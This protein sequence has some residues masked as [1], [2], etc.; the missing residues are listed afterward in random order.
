M[1][2]AWSGHRKYP[3][4][5]PIA[6]G[7]AHAD[8]RRARVGLIETTVKD[9][10]TTTSI[11]TTTLNR[12]ASL[13]RGATLGAV[14]ML[15]AVAAQAAA[16]FVVNTQDQSRVSVGMTR[17]E[18]RSALGRPAHNL[19]YRNEPGRTWTYGVS[20]AQDKV[21]DVDFSAEGK[22]LAMGVRT[23]AFATD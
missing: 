3:S 13:I 11:T 22:V 6:Q 4:S 19:K 10:M 16:G 1:G 23:E 5:R 20:G 8:A 9:T 2:R 18:V 14:L 7:A 15:G 12:T 17:D 21:F